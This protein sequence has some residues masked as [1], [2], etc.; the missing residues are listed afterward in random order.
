MA[1]NQDGIVT[2]PPVPREIQVRASMLAGL[3]SVRMAVLVRFQ[4]CEE[5][6]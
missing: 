6:P 2:A 5:T 3:P 4:C 1:S